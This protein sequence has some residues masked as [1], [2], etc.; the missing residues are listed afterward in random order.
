MTRVATTQR[1]HPP[2][3][4]VGL[5]RAGRVDYE[6]ALEW[7]LATAEAVAAG[8]DSGRDAEAVALLEHPPVYTFGVRAKREHLLA[9]PSALGA[10]G[11]TVVDT[12]RGGDVTFHGPGQLVAYPILDLRR[13][14]L[15]AAAYVRRL[16]A[17]VIE[18]VEMFGIQAER[19]AGRPGV[20]VEGAKIAAL[21][22]R[23]SRGV[24]RHGLALN[25]ST[26]LS[27]FEQ[28]VP[29][30]IP[31]AEVTSMQRLLGAAPPMC[32][33]EDAMAA[34]F[35]RVFDLELVEDPDTACGVAVPA[36]TARVR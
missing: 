21:G 34:A 24:S 29:C 2:Q 7:Q 16:E 9:T 35:E 12:D 6:P 28:I 4:R 17:V 5:W 31:D 15:G 8:R 22:V 1:D 14:E 11:A 19:V 3:P 32:A 13:R 36:G 25:V 30:G 18:T 10:R 23:I 27:W 26:D 20:W 33:V